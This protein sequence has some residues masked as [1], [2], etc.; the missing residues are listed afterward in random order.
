[1]Q[2]GVYN[3]V[4]DP[5]RCYGECLTGGRPIILF[6]E[7]AGLQMSPLSSAVEVGTAVPVPTLDFDAVLT[8]T[9]TEEPTQTPLATPTVLPTATVT[10]IP[11]VTHTPTSLPT[12]TPLVTETAESL[13]AATPLP[14][15]PPVTVG[16]PSTTTPAGSIDTTQLGLLVLG[17]AGVLAISLLLYVRVRRN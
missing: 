16:S 15:Q 14:T 11:T 7:G 6:E 5:A 2:G 1:A 3:L 10:P 8:L 4:L 12:L 9:P 17:I 13:Q